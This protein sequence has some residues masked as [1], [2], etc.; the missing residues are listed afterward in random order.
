MYTTF[1]LDE[2]GNR[3]IIMDWRGNPRFQWNEVTVADLLSQYPNHCTGLTF[4]YFW[5]G[6]DWHPQQHKILTP[7]YGLLPNFL[8]PDL[9]SPRRELEN[10]GP[11]ARSNGDKSA[12]SHLP[13]EC[14]EMAQKS[15]IGRPRI[16][17]AICAWNLDLPGPFSRV[18]PAPEPRPKKPRLPNMFATMMQKLIDEGK[19][20]RRQLGELF[21]GK[22]R[23]RNLDRWLDTSQAGQKR[24]YAPTTDQC[25]LLLSGLEGEDVEKYLAAIESDKRNFNLLKQWNSWRE[26][27]HYP[28]WA[29]LEHQNDTL[30]YHHRY[31]GRSIDERAEVVRYKIHSMNVDGI[32]VTMLE[33]EWVL[34]E[35]TWIGFAIAKTNIERRSAKQLFTDLDL[36]VDMDE[37]HETE[38]FYYGIH[39]VG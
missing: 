34:E 25:R 6:D 31:C 8:G 21:V 36:D 28:V 19:T 24:F 39:R 10:T 15:V 2:V 4:A 37:F 7:A 12:P 22:N 9:P 33:E 30:V 11:H 3:K 38:N 14:D 20:T 13:V 29:S 23:W 18:L 26:I 17:C 1:I 32:L 5:T 27:H 35:K 16:R